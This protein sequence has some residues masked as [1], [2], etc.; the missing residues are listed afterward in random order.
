MPTITNLQ[1]SRIHNEQFDLIEMVSNA[2]GRY[3]LR[4]AYW[5]FIFMSFMNE[6]LKLR[7]K[8]DAYK[9]NV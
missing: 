1:Q 7:T 5:D 4:F 9:Y 8:A 2:Q 3:P 6:S